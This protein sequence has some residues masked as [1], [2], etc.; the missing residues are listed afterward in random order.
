[1]AG[2][3]GRTGGARGNSGPRQKRLILSDKA[4]QELHI[5]LLHRRGTN[6]TLRAEDIVEQWIHECWQ[7]L[8]TLYQ[9]N[10]KILPR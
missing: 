7:E 2:V 8:D 10:S 9:E 1:M 3:K 4:A 5:I 6:A